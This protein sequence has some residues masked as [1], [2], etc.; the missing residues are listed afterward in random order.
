MESR[1]KTFKEFYVHALDGG[2]SERTD[3]TGVE[4]VP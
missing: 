4:K 2:R 3:L 1:D